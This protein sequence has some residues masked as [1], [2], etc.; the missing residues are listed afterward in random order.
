MPLRRRG[1]HHLEHAQMVPQDLCHIF[2]Q[3]LSDGE[4]AGPVAEVAQCRRDGPL[5]VFEESRLVG[6]AGRRRVDVVPVHKEVPNDQFDPV[7]CRCKRRREEG[8]EWLKAKEAEET[9][10]IRRP[11]D[12]KQDSTDVLT[13]PS[14]LRHKQAC[15][16]VFG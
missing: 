9:Q 8:E 12:R 6:D 7:A 3:Q 5:A 14:L 13:H 1:V 16:T 4:V 15:S 2:R 11:A 10:R